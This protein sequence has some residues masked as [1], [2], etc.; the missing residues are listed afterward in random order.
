[1]INEQEEF[2][3][4][5]RVKKV[6]S[7]S[8]STRRRLEAKGE[9]PRHCHLSPNRVAWPRSAILAWVEERKS[10]GAAATA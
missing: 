4:E 5:K 3:G 1:M 8:E 10:G 6:T 7:L 9:F 2:W